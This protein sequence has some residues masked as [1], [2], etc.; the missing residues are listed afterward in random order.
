MSCNSVYIFYLYF[1]IYKLV[2]FCILIRKDETS[3]FR[4]TANEALFNRTEYNGPSDKE[5]DHF[6]PT[7]YENFCTYK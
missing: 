2:L 7:Y 3:E 1:L 5:I 4:K 6:E